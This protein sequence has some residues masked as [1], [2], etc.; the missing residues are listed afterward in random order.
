MVRSIIFLI[1]LLITFQAQ[2]LSSADIIGEWEWL[3]DTTGRYANPDLAVKTEKT[4]IILFKGKTGPKVRYLDEY[5]RVC[6]DCS[7]SYGLVST[8]NGKPVFKYSGVWA[9]SADL[10]VIK[11]KSI[12]YNV[13]GALQAEAQRITYNKEKKILA[14]GTLVNNVGK[15]K[16]SYYK[17]R[18][19][20]AA[21]MSP[22]YSDKK[23]KFVNDIDIAK[24][25]LGM[26]PQSVISKIKNDFIINDVL[27]FSEH[28]NFTP[29]IDKIIAIRK[30]D[31][32]ID[33]YTFDFSKPPHDNQ[34]LAIHR[35][36]QFIFQE[37]MDRAPPTLKRVK[38][39]LMKKYGKA[40]AITNT[41]TNK[42]S[43]GKQKNIIISWRNKLKSCNTQFKPHNQKPPCPLLFDAQ[44]SSYAGNHKK[45][46]DIV[47]LLKLHLIN[48]PSIV[49]NEKIIHQQNK[50]H[51]I[52]K[53]KM[54]EMHKKKSL[55]FEL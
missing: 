50:M 53:I 41:N 21:S 10:M 7:G 11:R 13:S 43:N 22:Y 38:A 52:P 14:L 16:F 4:H 27:A 20:S 9:L 33:K 12:N 35:T 19:A 36:Q 37:D 44:L 6:S 42:G 3:G 29:Y 46:P 18:P 24:I 30:N 8:K 34:L 31:T 5:N 23:D 17:K 55:E 25:K 32:K 49:Q 39:V 47:N 28:N 48:Y 15:G 2:A 45:Y 1:T 26:T 54:Q 51:E 40:K